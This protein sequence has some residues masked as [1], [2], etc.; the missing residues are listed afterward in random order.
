ME[1]VNSVFMEYQKEKN[2]SFKKLPQ[3]NVD[4]G[5]GVERLLAAVENKQ[6]I[7]ATSLFDPIIKS[8]EKQTNKPYKGNEKE[9]R[10]I[11]DHLVSASFIISA[12]IYPS[13]KE[14]GYLLRKLIRRAIDQG[15]IREQ[16][17]S[18]SSQP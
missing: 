18:Q 17:A 4:H 10:I 5:A 14:Q 7:F 1:I 9:M 11:A 12:V 13:N 6:D 16:T 15:D 3:K 2:G 8:I